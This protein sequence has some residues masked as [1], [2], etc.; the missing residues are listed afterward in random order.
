MGTKK[1]KIKKKQV[2]SLGFDPPRKGL[3][4]IESIWESA[5]FSA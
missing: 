1:I 2:K 4:I 5:L 3:T